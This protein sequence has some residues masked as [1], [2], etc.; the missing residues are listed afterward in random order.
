MHISISSREHK[1]YVADTWENGYWCDIVCWVNGARF[2]AWLFWGYNIKA[3]YTFSK[4]PE[5]KAVY[6]VHRLW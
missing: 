4:E 6:V 2:I 3:E 1:K 5:Y